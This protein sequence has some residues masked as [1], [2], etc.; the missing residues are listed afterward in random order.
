M[1][2]SRLAQLLLNYRKDHDVDAFRGAKSVWIRQA[3]IFTISP[4]YGFASEFACSAAFLNSRRY[5]P[6]TPFHGGITIET[7]P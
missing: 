5:L 6:N 7:A 4:D 2:L 3:E 1:H